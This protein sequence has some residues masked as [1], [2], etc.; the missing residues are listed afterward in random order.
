MSTFLDEV[1]RSLA[2]P[3]P[4]RR[5]V[6]VLGGALASVA[7]SGV[8]SRSARAAAQQLDPCNCTQPPGSPPAT[9]CGLPR[10]AGCTKVCCVTASN[11][12]KC[13][14]WPGV[15]HAFPN[16][17]SYGC[18]NKPNS[19]PGF[20]AHTI[21][22]CPANTRCGSPT[23]GQLPCIPCATGR[24]PC[25]HKCCEL[26]KHCANDR[27]SLCC[28][29]GEVRCGRVC[30]ERGS[31]ADPGTSLCCKPGQTRCGRRCCHASQVCSGGSCRCTSGWQKCGPELCCDKRI[32]VCA[33]VGGRR[34]T[35]YCCPRYQWVAQTS[36][37]CPR[38]T[39][40]DGTGCCSLGLGNKN[41]CEG[42]TCLA[43]STCVNGS[44]RLL[45]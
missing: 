20:E 17:S 29:K 12:P 23:P 5:A 22:C 38:F 35:P 1:A 9:R 45:R 16:S 8:V 36:T 25:G 39:Y 19:G 3:M 24:Q 4:R 40:P 42:V 31:C 43:G 41:C 21:C 26:G 13:C 6:R 37:C 44:C 32:E 34:T 2:Q 33:P 10:G 14:Q 11:L 30:C 28:R 7:M 18:I 15:D 27:L